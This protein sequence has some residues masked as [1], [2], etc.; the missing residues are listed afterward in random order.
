MI[1]SATDIGDSLDII[2]S[3]GSECGALLAVR[4]IWGKISES[5]VYFIESPS[6]I[7]EDAVV[8][9][10]SLLSADSPFIG[11]MSADE[12]GHPTNSR[13]NCSLKP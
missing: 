7:I 4:D 9:P 13:V 11:C 8:D 2:I 12:D 5:S 3:G 1:L 6:D 10:A